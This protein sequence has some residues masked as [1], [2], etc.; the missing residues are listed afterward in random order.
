I[1]EKGN[2]KLVWENNRECYHCVANHPEL[3]KTFPEAPSVSGVQGA[4]D[5]PEIAA[6][7]QRCEAAGL[8]SIF[9]M[10]DDGQYRA[11]RVPL[12]RDAESY[13]MS[14]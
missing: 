6:H 5:D 12:L 2:W 7:W 3:C 1:V 10:S 13:T 14:G 4:A 11:T 8:P 9:R